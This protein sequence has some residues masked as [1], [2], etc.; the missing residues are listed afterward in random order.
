MTDIMTNN[1]S[2]NLT[3]HI[4]TGVMPSVN[5]EEDFFVRDVAVNS[6]FAVGHF[7]S[8]GEKLNYLFHLMIMN[9]G[10]QEVIN[11]NLSI[12]NET[13]GWYHADDKVY[14]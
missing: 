5:P 4:N 14:P 13:T 10:G 12:T 9:R 6:W 2:E 7:E 11:S 1:I 3:K 8:N